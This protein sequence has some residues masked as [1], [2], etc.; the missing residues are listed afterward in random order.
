MATFKEA[1][2]KARKELGAGKTFTWN[3]KSYSTN[4]EGEDKGATSPKPKARPATV[5]NKTAAKK[6]TATASTATTSTGAKATVDTRPGVE[7]AKR[8]AARSK[9]TEEERRKARREADAAATISR[10]S[11]ATLA[12][13]K[14]DTPK[15]RPSLPSNPL[16]SIAAQKKERQRYRGDMKRR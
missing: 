10:A 15:P 2:A 1:F 3:G 11:R 13:A 4:V 9:M 14:A 12:K 7:T 8:V 16:P 5:T 6:A